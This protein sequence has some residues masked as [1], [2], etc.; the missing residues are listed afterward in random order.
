MENV[1][2]VPLLSNTTPAAL[3]DI[4]AFTNGQTGKDNPQRQ[5]LASAIQDGLS[6]LNVVA[7]TPN[8][9]SYSPLWALNMAKWIGEPGKRACICNIDSKLMSYHSVHDGDVSFLM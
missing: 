7:N 4:V 8:S 3:I 2:Y 1:P 9:P 6:P 5:G